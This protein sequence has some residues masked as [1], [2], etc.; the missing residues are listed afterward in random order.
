[1]D[2]KYICDECG[3]IY[4]PEEEGKPFSEQPDSYKCP[5]CGVPKSEFSPY[6]DDEDKVEEE[7]LG[8]YLKRLV[9]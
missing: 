3:W 1:M 4:D 7:F 2:K 5:K 9:K 6:E 8:K